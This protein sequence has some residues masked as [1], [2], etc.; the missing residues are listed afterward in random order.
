MTILSYNTIGDYMKTIKECYSSLQ[1]IQKSE[2]IANIYPVSSIEE[3]MISSQKYAKNTMM[4]R[5]TAMLM[6]LGL[7]LIL[8]KQVMMESQAKLQV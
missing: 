1:T 3:I 8:L 6:S 7:M 4:L 5:T 2:F